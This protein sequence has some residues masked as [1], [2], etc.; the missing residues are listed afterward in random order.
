MQKLKECLHSGKW[1]ILN[2]EKEKFQR[3]YCFSDLQAFEQVEKELSVTEDGILLR[4]ARI[5]MPKALREKAVEIAHEGHSGDKRSNKRKRL[6]P[7]N[8]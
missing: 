3:N 8:R 6:V 5:V 2:Q 4:G 1:S 7:W